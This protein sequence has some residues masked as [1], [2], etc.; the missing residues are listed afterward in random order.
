MSDDKPDAV[1]EELIKQAIIFGFA[2]VT[3]VLYTVGQRKMGEPDFVADFRAWL[4]LVPRPRRD[5]EA[6]ALEQV[7]REISLLEH[8]QA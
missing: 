1:R 6:E 8:G 2:V 4:G 3:L 5:T 7:Q